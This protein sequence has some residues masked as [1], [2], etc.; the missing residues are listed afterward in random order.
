MTN[1]DNWDNLETDDFENAWDGLKES[2]DFEDLEVDIPETV[3]VSD[4]INEGSAAADGDYEPAEPRQSAPVR[5]V[6]KVTPRREENEEDDYDGFDEKKGNGA[7]VLIIVIAALIIGGLV[8]LAIKLVGGSSGISAASDSTGETTTEAP[9]TADWQ[10]NK[11]SDVVSLINSYYSS[12]TLVDTFTLKEILDPAVSVDEAALT[13]EASVIEGYRDITCYMTE[14]KYDG[15]WVVYVRYAIKFKNIATPAPGLVG[16][17]VRPD[18]EGKLRLIPSGN[19]QSDSSFDEYKEFIGLVSECDAIRNLA[20][21]VKDDYVK[22]AQ[23]DSNLNEYLYVLTG[24]YAAGDDPE[25]TSGDAAG[26]TDATAEPGGQTTEPTTEAPTTAA[27]TTEA[28]TTAA[29]TTKA[30]AE[31]GEFETVDTMMYITKDGVNVRKQPNTDSEVVT[32]VKTGDYIQI[33][34]K[35]SEWYRVCL[36]DGTTAYIKKDFFSN[37]KPAGTN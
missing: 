23:S 30:P 31:T 20:A 6:R 12:R 21:E 13:N 15:E 11:D 18:G 36:K 17:Y 10:M 5:P 35:G 22:A 25:T 29:P 33:T 9:T 32:T 8:F 34:G 3:E 1:N 28:P 37:D 27:P 26:Q 7:T 4:T 2:D 14:G 24:T 19:V 16:H